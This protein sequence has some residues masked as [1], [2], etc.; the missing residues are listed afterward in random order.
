MV[1]RLNGRISLVLIN[2]HHYKSAMDLEQTLWCDVALYNYQLPQSALD[3]KNT[4]SGNE[5]LV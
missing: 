3:S 2:T 4:N 5:G 1:E